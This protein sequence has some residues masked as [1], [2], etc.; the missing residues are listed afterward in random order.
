MAENLYDD[1]FDVSSLA[2]RQRLFFLIFSKRF[3][4]DLSCLAFF[5][6]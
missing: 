5:I 6:L 2:K 3:M 4:N 1:S